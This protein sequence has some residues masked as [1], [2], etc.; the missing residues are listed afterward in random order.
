MAVWALLPEFWTVPT[1]VRVP[2]EVFLLALPPLTVLFAELV[3]LVV[4]LPVL[5]PVALP[6]ERLL[7][8]RLLPVVTFPVELLPV[9]LLPVVRR[10]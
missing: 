8:A 3:L 1:D 5:L 6:V 2:V 4:E 10:T 7:L 9:L